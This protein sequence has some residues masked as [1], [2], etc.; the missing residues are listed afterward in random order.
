VGLATSRSAIGK[1]TIYWMTLKILFRKNGLN[2]RI[3]D[4]GDKMAINEACQVWIEQRIEEELEERKK[5]G[6]SLRAI[7]KAIAKEIE[8]VFEAK[9]APETIASRVKRASKQAGSNEPPES[10]NEKKPITYESE[11][12]S[13][14]HPQTNRGGKRDGSGRKPKEY[15]II[16][17]EN[18]GNIEGTQEF[19]TAFEAFY[20]QVQNAQLE[21][22]Q[23]VPK[24]TAISCITY[25]KNLIGE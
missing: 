14:T 24:H 20:T 7:G 11:E 21:K 5:N 8:Q 13:A 17:T 4:G 16:E 1:S 15:N 18:F 3:T 22:W 10:N 12:G 9:V 23:N 6:K 25:L 2:L 19:C